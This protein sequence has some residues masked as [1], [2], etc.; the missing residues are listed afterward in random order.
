MLKKIVLAGGCFWGVEELLRQ[1]PGVIKTMVGYTGGQI[2]NPTYEQH[3]GHAE[4]VEITY[5]RYPKH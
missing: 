3:D 2:T 4:A 1:Q 5:G